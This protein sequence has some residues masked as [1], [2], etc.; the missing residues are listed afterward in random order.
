MAPAHRDGGD[1]ACWAS[2]VCVECGRIPD[3]PDGPDGDGRCPTC[4]APPPLSD[5]QYRSL[6]E[7][8]ASL[9][10]FLHSS[11]IAARGA[12]LT[13]THHQLLLAIRGWAGSQPPSISDL[14]E[15]LQ[16]QVHSAGELVARAETAGLVRR[17]P[18]PGDGRRQ[19]VELR[20]EGAAQLEA[21]SAFHLDQ[22]RH[23]RRRMLDVLEDLEG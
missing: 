18:D 9:R 21:L 6:A 12:G 4:A 15:R 19:H 13:P 8:R 14:A 5:A 16:L 23:L 20:A 2:Q 7:F 11:E 22:L 10:L 1:P 17:S 3:P